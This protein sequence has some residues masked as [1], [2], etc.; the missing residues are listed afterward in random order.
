MKYQKSKLGYLETLKL[1]C[2]HPS[3]V[4]KHPKMAEISA[5]ADGR[6]HTHTHTRTDKLKPM[7]FRIT[8][9]IQKHSRE[10]FPFI[11]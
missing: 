4:E 5:N 9:G 1:A 2:H 10:N 3:L 8:Y 6:T 7:D 11:F